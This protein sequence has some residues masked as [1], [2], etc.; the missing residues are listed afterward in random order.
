MATA[1][2]T[3]QCMCGAVKLTALPKAPELHACQCDMCRRWC[4]SAFV[5]FDVA[6]EGLDVSGPVKSFVSSDWAE[7]AW[8]D[9]CGSTLWYKLTVPGHETYAVSAG[10]FDN[11]GGF[12]LTKEIY[13]DRAPDGYSFAGAITRVTKQ[14]TEAQFASLG[15]GETP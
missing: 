9:A 5:E 10:L 6:P 1:E 14:Q 7:R 12:R 4:G 15:E 11:A 2:R 8:C 3:G 13:S